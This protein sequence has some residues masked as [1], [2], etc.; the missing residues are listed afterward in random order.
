M[1][2][3]RHMMPA[4]SMTEMR[5]VMVKDWEKKQ[6][7]AMEFP[8]PDVGGLHMPREQRGHILPLSP[9]PLFFFSTS[10]SSHLSL[11]ALTI[12]AM[13]KQCKKERPGDCVAAVW[14][15]SEVLRGE[16]G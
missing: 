3:E 4:E 7:A 15:W 14:G 16:D 2:E 10:P 9:P 12:G 6:E 8:H 1:H 13:E 11:F 5:G